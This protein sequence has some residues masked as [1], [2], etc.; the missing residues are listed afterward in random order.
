M[1][2]TTKLKPSQ[3]PPPDMLHLS[4]SLLAAVSAMALRESPPND[5]I[6]RDNSF[7]TAIAGMEKSLSALTLS[8]AYSGSTIKIFPAIAGS[9]AA[10]ACLLQLRCCDISISLLPPSSEADMQANAQLV[11]W[12]S[13][14]D[15]CLVG[16]R[17]VVEVVLEGGDEATAQRVEAIGGG[18][19]GGGAA[20]AGGGGGGSVEDEG[21]A[22]AMCCG[23]YA[24]CAKAA[25]AMIEAAR[26][27]AAARK[28][29]GNRNAADVHVDNDDDHHDDDDA[30]ADADNDDHSG[31]DDNDVLLDC[32]P[33]VDV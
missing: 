18:G 13:L 27:S 31:S 21:L 29:A 17:K 4:L 1:I 26:A 11:A 3:T 32:S 19:G 22:L 7:F 20:A 9:L 15:R 16:L 8:G 2:S 5:Q 6:V 25:T 14:Y 10:S 28:V 12:K 30:D 24:A 23:C 33:A